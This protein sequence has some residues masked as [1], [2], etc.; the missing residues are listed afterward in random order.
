MELGG[1]M[2]IKTFTYTRLLFGHSAKILKV[3]KTKTQAQAQKTQNC[4]KFFRNLRRFSTKY[5]NFGIKSGKKCS[6]TQEF[7]Q[8]SR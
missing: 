6:K 1:R 5:N 7:T 4:G 2:G 3:K 8:N